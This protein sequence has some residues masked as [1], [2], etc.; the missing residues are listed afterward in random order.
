MRAGVAIALSCALLAGC[1]K[2]ECQTGERRPCYGGP[3][4]TAGV[5][6]C[7]EGTQSC[8]AGRWEGRCSGQVL[9]S[10]EICD[11]LDNDCNGQVDDGVANACGGCGV[12][13]AAPGAACASCGA[14]FCSSREALTC[15]LPASGPGTACTSASGCPG[16]FVCSAG[17]QVICTAPE[18]N[19]CGLCGG[20]KVSGLGAPCGGAAPVCTG[21][22]VCNPAGDAAV[23]SGASVGDPCTAANGCAGTK[24]C[25]PAGLGTACVATVQTNEC[26]LCGGPPVPSAGQPCTSSAGT[27]GLQTCNAAGDAASCAGLVVT[28][29]FD[30]TFDDSYQAGA[31]LEAHGMRGVFYV[32]STRFTRQGYMTLPQVQSLQDRGHEIGGHTLDHPHLPLL[33]G[34]T[35]RVEICNDRTRLLQ[36]G[37]DVQS[38]A[39]PFGEADAVTRAAAAD[40]NYNS[41]RGIGGLAGY[42]IAA[43]TFQPR[44]VFQI[45]APPSVSSTTTLATMQSYVTEAEATGGWLVINMHHVCDSCST[46]AVSPAILAAFLDWLQPRT[47]GG[48]L[49]RTTRQMISGLTKPP[50]IWSVLAPGLQNLL[51]N[52]S[53]EQRAPGVA[54]PL[55]WQQLSSGDLD[56]AWSS[57]EAHSGTQAQSVTITNYQGGAAGL[58]LAEDDGQC[59]PPVS[60]SHTYQLSAFYLSPVLAPSFTVFV[61]DGAGDW[62][63]WAQSPVFPPRAFY[64]QAVWTAP[65]LPEDATAISIGL[66]AAGQ[67]QLTVDDFTLTDLTP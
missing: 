10:A 42:H 61:R 38:F 2:P 18:R 62:S 51:P 66:F 12:L 55:C 52:P 24:Q 16:T 53:L 67:G 23:C 46:I 63:T 43:E 40:C 56:A 4:G 45:R 34:D 30:D 25:D 21:T 37:L 57:G 17:G 58:A 7:K 29:T 32:N 60:P 33:S 49:V 8:V 31:M 41:A 47:A 5:G 28:L 50:V 44:D 14:F 19:A 13:T 20:P 65:P 54:A 9:P 6:A 3:A 35:Q 26:G 36:L 15:A 1:K 11:G 39:Y 22:V 59:A 64:D 27:A 48:T